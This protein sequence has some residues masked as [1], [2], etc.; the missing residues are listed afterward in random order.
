MLLIYTRKIRANFYVHN[1]V[2]YV[3]AVCYVYILRSGA[4]H[5]FKEKGDPYPKCE[6]YRRVTTHKQVCRDL[7]LLVSVSFVVKT[8]LSGF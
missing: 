1:D 4:D 8:R 2:W 5:A 3:R 7:F 6:T